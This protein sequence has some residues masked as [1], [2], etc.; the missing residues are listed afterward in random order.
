MSED[1]KWGDQIEDALDDDDAMPFGKHKGEPM[2]EVPAQ[3][4]LWFHE[5]EWASKWPRVK[6][7]VEERM[8]G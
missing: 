2:S 7:Y 1:L 4:L 5:Q 3:Y 6:L 8:D